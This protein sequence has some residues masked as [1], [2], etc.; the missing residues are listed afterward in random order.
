MFK[1]SLFPLIIFGLLICNIALAQTASTGILP[2]AHGAAADANCVNRAAE[3][4]QDPRTYCGNYELND[5][6][7]LGINIARWILGIVGSLCLFMFIMG[8]QELLLSGG[9]SE[10]VQKGKKIFVAA[11]IGLL[12]VLGSFL[13][14]K[15]SLGIIGL[16]WNGEA[17]DSNEQPIKIKQLPDQPAAPNQ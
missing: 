8:G 11:I 3:L 17:F 10:K 15:A 9:S 4:K 12:I 14:I 6:I 2:D 7:R 1:K 5:F 16:D 13:I